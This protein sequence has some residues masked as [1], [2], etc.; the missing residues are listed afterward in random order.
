MMFFKRSKILIVAIAAILILAFP[1]NAYAANYTVVKGDSLYIIGKLFNTDAGTIMSRNNLPGSMIYPGQKL[2][3][4]SSTYTV[5]SGDSLYLIAKKYGLSLDS[6]RRINNKW[7]NMIY[8][9]QKLVMPAGIGTQ[10]QA[11]TKPSG[12]TLSKSGV[13]YT[14]A[15]VELL[16]RLVTAEAQ[17]QP[18]NAQVGVAAVVLNRVKDSYFPNNIYDVIYQKIDRFYQFTP[19]ENGWIN[20]SATEESRKA[21]YEALNGSDP[22]KGAL[23]YF[24][25]SATNKWL[26]S[27]PILA[28][29]GRMVFV[30]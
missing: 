25:D 13:Y 15:D 9:G 8:P 2:D 4:P 6:L 18:F 11:P 3:I 7:D 14:Q 10:N 28:Y 19:V 21:V 30:K 1:A 29:I 16:A 23:F 22:S 12:K 26:W 27:K 20:K 17:G 5:K 24:D